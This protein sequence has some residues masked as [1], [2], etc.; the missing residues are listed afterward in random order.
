MK[1]EQITETERHTEKNI[2]RKGH[3]HTHTETET[4][5]DRK[6]YYALRPTKPTGPRHLKKKK[7]KK[8]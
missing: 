6:A 8:K 3:S 2:D 7:K 5:R 1:V 4:Q